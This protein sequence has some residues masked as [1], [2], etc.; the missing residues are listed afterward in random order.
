MIEL[1]ILAS[2]I[3][4]VSLIASYNGY[5]VGEEFSFLSSYMLLLASFLSNQFDS[6]IIISASF[7]TLVMHLLYINK[8]N[9]FMKI[10]DPIVTES[11]T[12]VEDP[13]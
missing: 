6:T 3:S 2:Y 4:I 12:K 11:E 1:L 13:K 10:K 8:K 7:F 5:T 9:G